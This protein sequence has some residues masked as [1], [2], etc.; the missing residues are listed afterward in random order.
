M[1]PVITKVELITPATAKEYLK[2]NTDNRPIRSTHVQR[3]KE[4]MMA[5]RWLV[6]HQGIAFDDAGKLL[7]GQH[8][9]FAVAMSGVPVQMMVTRGLA[10]KADDHDLYTMDV[11]DCG[12][13]RSTADQLTLMHGVAH[14]SLVTATCRMLCYAA[15]GSPNSKTISPTVGQAVQIIALYREGFDSLLEF[16][17]KNKLARLAPVVAALSMGYIVDKDLSLEF[18]LGLAEG[19]EIKRGEPIYALREHLICKHTRATAEARYRLMELTAN[20]FFHALKGN[21][22]MQA[23]AGAQGLDYLVS[24]QKKHVETVLT[25]MGR[26]PGSEK[27]NGTHK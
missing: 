1:K 9:L 14:A 21:E 5:G 18:M 8:R 10:R 25:I 19:E 23:K 7:D 3:L 2:S 20:C 26:K 4:E 13:A 6:T 12:R 27:T 11:I 24:K 17:G 22:V 15:A 16:A